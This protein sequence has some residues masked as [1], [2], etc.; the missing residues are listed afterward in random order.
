MNKQIEF[1]VKLR[2]ASLML[3]DAA[4]HYLDELTP[5]EKKSE[6][7]QTLIVQE[8]NFNSL[9]FD[10]QQSAKLG[11]YEIAYKQNNPAEQWSSVYNI[12]KGGNAT[13]QD[14]YHCEG[15]QYSYWLYG[16]DKIYRQKLKPKS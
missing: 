10:A 13:I 8:S 7:E 3:A 11:A 12:L 15:Y 6:T 4:N 5:A 16:E 1:L 2:D 14:R 9:K